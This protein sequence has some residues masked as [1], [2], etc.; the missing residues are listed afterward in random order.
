MKMMFCLGLCDKAVRDECPH[1]K[2][3]NWGNI[4]EITVCCESDDG[5]S[6]CVEKEVKNESSK[7]S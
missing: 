5:K 6:K 2:A 7:S 4:C 1:G 3:H